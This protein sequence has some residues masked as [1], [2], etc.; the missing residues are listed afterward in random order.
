MNFSPLHYAAIATLVAIALFAFLWQRSETLKLNKKTHFVANLLG[1]LF[2]LLLT[3]RSI[4]SF[5]AG[6][7]LTDILYA[8]TTAI[9]A[10]LYLARKYPSDFE[11]NPKETV[12]CLVAAWGVLFVSF[13]PGVVLS[14]ALGTGVLGTGL[15]LQLISKIYLGRSYALFAAN[16][17]VVSSGP[18]RYVRHPIYLAYLF[19]SVG[20]LLAHLSLYNIAIYG[21]V[22]T[23]QI[24]RIFNEER[25]LSRSEDYTAYKRLVRYRLIPYVW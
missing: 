5:L 6:K 11:P 17:G 3:T 25:I 8:I 18:Y 20:F 2:S 10:I 19:I 24:W 23:L 21:V 1:A 16:R 14:P 15:I 4:Y 13:E 7:N 22:Y 9:E 12:I